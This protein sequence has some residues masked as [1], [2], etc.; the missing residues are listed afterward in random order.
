MDVYTINGND[1]CR[2]AEAEKNKWVFP[3]DIENKYNNAAEIYASAAIQYKQG[4]N[5]YAAATTYVQEALIYETKLDNMTSAYES[6]LNAAKCFKQDSR[7]QDDAILYFT[8]T[9]VYNKN[10]GRESPAETHLW[11]HYHH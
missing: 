11:K 2:Q 3:W 10:T 6:Y 1:L 9:A 5:Y 4:K 8:Q 7:S